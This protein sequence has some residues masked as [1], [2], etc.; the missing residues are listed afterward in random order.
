MEK[1]K[2][3]YQQAR[4]HDRGAAEMVL[5]MISASKGRKSPGRSRLTGPSVRS[6]RLCLWFSG[7]LGATVTVT[8]KLGISILNGGNT[9]VQQVHA[10][11]HDDAVHGIKTKCSFWG[12][13]V[14]CTGVFHAENA[15]LPEGEKRCWLLQKFIW[16]HD[17]LQVMELIFVFLNFHH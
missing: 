4:L 17:V 5:Q 10:V 14:N 2:M 9:L 1:Q 15:G 16:T 7:R 8:L 6:N 12:E 3:L 11:L 13:G